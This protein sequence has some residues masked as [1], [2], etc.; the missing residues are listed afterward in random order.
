MAATAL[1]H[2]ISPSSVTPYIQQL[3]FLTAALSMLHSTNGPFMPYQQRVVIHLTMS[4]TLPANQRQSRKEQWKH[5]IKGDLQTHSSIP[6]AIQE[7][8]TLFD[9]TS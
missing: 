5:S 7:G 2:G 4:T 1:P 8:V 3:F 6:S 9:Y